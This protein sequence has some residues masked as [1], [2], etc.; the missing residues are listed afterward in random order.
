MFLKT[1][2]YSIKYAA[3]KSPPEEEEKPEDIWPFEPPALR[4]H[5]PCAPTQLRTHARTHERTNETNPI[6]RLGFP[7]PPIF[8]LRFIF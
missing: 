3:G 2:V 6:S 5:V 7:Q 8:I 1:L 4:K